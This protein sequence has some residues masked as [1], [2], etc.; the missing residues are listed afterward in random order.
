M[1]PSTPTQGPASNASTRAGR[2]LADLILSS[3]DA[4]RFFAWAATVQLGEVFVDGQPWEPIPVGEAAES[5]FAA[6]E[7]ARS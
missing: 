3:A 2:T 1:S 5:D 7:E 4:A 6:F